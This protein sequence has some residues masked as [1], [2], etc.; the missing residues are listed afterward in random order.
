[1]V[2]HPGLDA[3]ALGVLAQKASI[4]KV[5]LGWLSSTGLTAE[6]LQFLAKDRMT[7]WL[8]F[9]EAAA[10]PSNLVRQIQARRR[11]RGIAGE[12]VTER[13][14]RK[15]FPGYRLS[16]RQVVLKEGS[17]VDFELVAPDGSL[18]HAVE[19]K[20]WTGDTWRKALKAW[21]ASQNAAAKLDAEQEQLVAQLR[22]VIKQ[23]NDAARAPRGRPF[24]T[25]S[26][27]LS[28]PTYKKLQRFLQRNAPE[29]QLELVNEAEM[30]AVTKRL[31]A[32][33]NLPEKLP[34]ETSGGAP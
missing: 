28:E 15:L 12:M 17:I 9:Q 25:A 2:R 21:D 3:E 29:T 23:L 34:R 8:L 7:N 27:K 5:D 11:L 6:E 33:F 4:R 1:M 26:D 16:G 19:V 24:L 18:R 14:A 20:G 10:E 22:N 30:L 13:T 32:A 31:R